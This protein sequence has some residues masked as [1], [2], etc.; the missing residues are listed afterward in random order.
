MIA[1]AWLIAHAVVGATRAI[2]TIEF[3][4]FEEKKRGMDACTFHL[5]IYRARRENVIDTLPLAL[6]AIS[7]SH[8]ILSFGIF[9]QIVE[10]MLTDLMKNRTIWTIVEITSNEYVSIWNLNLDFLIAQPAFFDTSFFSLRKFAS[11][12]PRSSNNSETL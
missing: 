1:V 11:N 5:I 4:I 8:T 12:F 2:A 3:F 6:I 10:A 7:A 9:C